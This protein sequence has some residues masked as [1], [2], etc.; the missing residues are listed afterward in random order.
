MFACDTGRRLVVLQTM[1]LL[2]CPRHRFA[3][4][5]RLGVRIVPPIPGFYRHPET[6]DDLVDF[7]VEKILGALGEA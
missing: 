3:C 2:C 5:A 6:L 7:V 1:D 4:L